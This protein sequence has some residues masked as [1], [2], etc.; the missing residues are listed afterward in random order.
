MKKYTN[1]ELKLNEFFFKETIIYPKCVIIINQF[2]FFVIQDDLI[3][4]YKVKKHLFSL[5]TN[6]RKK[7]IIV[8]E[9]STL[10]DLVHNLFPDIFI[11]NI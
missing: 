11:Y 10:I 1:Y 4:Y 3:T 2:V 8:R 7:I 6:L 5:R 9:Q